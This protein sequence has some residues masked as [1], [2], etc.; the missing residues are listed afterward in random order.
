MAEEGAPKADGERAAPKKEP[1]HAALAKMENVI[2][3]LKVLDYEEKYLAAKG[4]E[5]ISRWAFDIVGRSFT[6]STLTVTSASLDS[7]GAPLSV[8]RTDNVYEGATSK[9]RCGVDTLSCACSGAN[10]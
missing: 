6:S 2:D 1:I 5:P 9:L 3:K 10:E 4:V 8:T 7:G